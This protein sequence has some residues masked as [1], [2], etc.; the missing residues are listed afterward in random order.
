MTFTDVIFQRI[1]IKSSSKKYRPTDQPVE[2]PAAN[3]K[4]KRMHESILD[5]I[6]G[7]RLAGSHGEKSTDQQQRSAS[8]NSSVGKSSDQERA[9]SKKTVT[10]ASVFDFLDDEKP[11]EDHQPVGMLLFIYR[12]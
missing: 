4:L 2:R 3:G 7:Y 1:Q 8:T 6:S 5:L 12:N 10:F 9:V 11:A